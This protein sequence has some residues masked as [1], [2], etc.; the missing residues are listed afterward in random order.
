MAQELGLGKM[1]YHNSNGKR[2]YDIPRE[3]VRRKE[4]ED[5]CIMI[6][7]RDIIKIIK[8]QNHGFSS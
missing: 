7:T 2:H 4:I 6:S 3:P 8:H 5:K 1:W